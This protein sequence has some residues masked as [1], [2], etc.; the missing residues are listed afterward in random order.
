M[1]SITEAAISKNRVTLAAL[2]AVLVGGLVAYKNL[3]RAEDPGFIIRVAQVV[4][5]FPG[6]SPERV[7]QLV[8]DPLEKAIQEM[9]ELDRVTSQSRTGVSIV[10]VHIKESY[11]DM[12]PI[13][14]SLRRKV[15]RVQAELPDDALASNVNDEFGEVFGIVVTLT[16]DGFSYAELKEVADSVRDEFLLLD[17]VAKVDIYGA[18]E[19]RLFVEYSNA[20]LSEVGLSP[21]QLA[22]ILS[23]R[24]I[25]IPGGD[26]STG[27]ERLVLEPSGSFESVADVASSLISLPVTGEVVALRD[28][29]RVY[30]GYIDPPEAKLS[31]SGTDALGL[32]IAMREGGN[33]MALGDQVQAK[34]AEMQAQYPI[35]LELETVAFQPSEV[36]RIIEVFRVNLLQAIGIVTIIMLLALGL[37]TGFIVASLIPCTMIMSLMMMNIFGIG[38]DQISLAALIIA[39]GMLVD[40][41]IVMSENTLIQME[42]GKPAR[43]AAI[44]SAQELFVPLL[45]ASLTTAAAFLPIY[46]AE[47]QTGEYTAP[48]FKVVAI[49]L[50]CSWLIA[51]TVIPLLSAK[52]M[53]VKATKQATD[54]SPYDSSG[55]RL[56]RTVLQSML[57]FRW[58]TLGATA[59]VFYIAMVGFSHVPALFFPDADKPFVRV[60]IELPFGAPLE[61]TEDTVRAVEEHINAELLIGDQRE[62]GVTSWAAYIGGSGPRFVL[63]HNPQPNRTH[64]A[65]MLVNTTG[66][67]I[68]DH[69]MQSVREFTQANFPDVKLTAKRVEYGPPVS[70]PVEVRLSG[71][72]LNQLFE[73]AGTVKDQ[74]RTMPGTINVDDNWGARIKKLR[75]DIDEARAR[76]AGISN[77][78]IA[79][80]LQSALSGIELTQYREGDDIIPITLRSVQSD[81]QDLGKLETLNVQSQSTGS[82]VPL[83]Q[84]ADIE[85]EW[86]PAEMIRRN[87]LKTITVS[88][89]L[90][91]GTASEINS[92][93]QPWLDA[94]Q[95]N[96][97]PGYRW[98]FGGEAESAGD[99]N[100][101]IAEK[102][103]IALFAILILLV[104][105][106]NSIRKTLIVLAT[107]PLALIGVSAG[108]LLAGSYMGF[109]TTLG[110]VSL[111]GI[112]INNAIVLLERIDIERNKL[113]RSPQAA[114]IE[115]AQRR[116]RPIL[117]TTATTVLGLVP[118]WY[119]G[120]LMWEPMAVSIIFGLLFST[121]LT[122]GIIPVLYA[123]FYRVK[124][125]RDAV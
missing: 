61:R 95:P 45:T 10:L 51:L 43:T 115:A 1:M 104:L 35:G 19:E 109:M 112:V 101:A 124:F 20:R 78:D 102:M 65:F 81:R 123:L 89:G 62:Q 85:I 32:A 71:R 100:A 68:N 84:V 27:M 116:L 63:Q 80:S 69:V 42:E 97:G 82:S 41:A 125:S 91:S 121:V 12:R 30:R 23:S 79:I 111:A 66:N 50:L 26:I 86:Q 74:L 72:D 75:I 15:D 47:S 59:V 60:E 4:T 64:Y 94:Q 117:L 120:G 92:Q 113:G 93:L 34:L 22:E 77:R 48:L 9:P 44:N 24:N 38:L 99:S 33:I 8:T 56:Y 5:I 2:F 31:S 73:I 21:G 25:I 53:R 90:D 88:A 108:L 58:V 52:F 54:K 122:L 76:R 36:S 39:L 114:I 14:D 16:G 87:R 28:I 49:T 70:N 118:L 96:W 57:R 6:A 83:Q 107:I 46:L 13:W 106:F 29:A 67:D 105:Q 7:E 11:T 55:Y 110:I 3:P 18:Q 119:G 98:E 37:R 17:L 40:N 103:P